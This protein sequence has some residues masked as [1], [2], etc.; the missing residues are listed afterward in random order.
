MASGLF[1]ACCA[2]SDSDTLIACLTPVALREGAVC[3]PNKSARLK[4]TP[5]AF[6][7]RLYARDK[8]A[9]L[10]AAIEQFDIRPRFRDR[11][12]ARRAA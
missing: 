3:K 10:K 11:L 1:F 2:R 7:G 8:A 6:V 5:A 4:G 12:L 9:A